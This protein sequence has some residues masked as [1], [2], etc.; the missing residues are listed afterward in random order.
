MW[1][2]SN[3]MPASRVLAIKG[4]AR[5]AAA[6]GDATA[7]PQ[8]ELHRRHQGRAAGHRKALDLDVA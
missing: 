5:D 4:P 8:H 1:S 7:L 2:A 3:L 6:F